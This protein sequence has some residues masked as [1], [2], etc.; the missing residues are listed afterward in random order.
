MKPRLSKSRINTFKQCPYRYYVIN[1]ENYQPKTLSPHLIKGSLIHDAFDNYFKTGM[2]SLKEYPEHQ[3]NFLAFNEWVK[4]K[5]LMHEEKF[6]DK[7]WNFA[8]ILD[9]YQKLPDGKTLLLD[10][11]TGKVHPAKD[12]ELELGL[13]AHLIMQGG[14]E[15]PDFVGIFFTEHDLIDYIPCTEELI[16]AAVEEMH[17]VSEDIENKLSSCGK[18]CFGKKKSKLCDYC[19]LYND[20]V[21]EGIRRKKK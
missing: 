2:I 21:C 14:W 6:V 4:E 18:E 11:K 20:G 16:S 3:K 8:G 17:S 5:P 19:E 10:Y 12:Y 15:R 7:E 13:Y 1:I 9:R